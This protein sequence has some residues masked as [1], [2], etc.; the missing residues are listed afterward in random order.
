MEKIIPFY[1]K[2]Y[3]DSKIIS[4]EDCHKEIVYRE[5]LN[6]LEIARDDYELE[7]ILSLSEENIPF[8]FTET[9]IGH[10]RDII[11]DAIEFD[12]KIDLSF[13]LGELGL[14]ELLDSRMEVDPRETK[15]ILKKIRNKFEKGEN[16][17][18]RERY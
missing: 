18:R 9:M 14:Y 4:I 6:L 16:Y 17:E 5:I 10:F 7:V 15:K 11:W 8:A 13:V 1:R 3:T 12:S 2:S